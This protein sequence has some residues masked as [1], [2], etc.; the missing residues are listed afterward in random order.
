MKEFDDLKNVWSQDEPATFDFARA[1]NNTNNNPISQMKKHYTLSTLG[2]SATTTFIVWFGFFSG[3]EFMFEISYT[4]LT[5]LSVCLS[6]I[7]LINI[8]TV[9]LISKL[10]ET[11]VPKEYLNNWLNFY[12]KRLRFFRVYAPILVTTMTFSFALYVPEIMGYY[13]NMYYKIGFIFFLF[14]ILFTSYLLGKN[15]ADAEKM[16]LNE[17]NGTFQSL[18]K[19]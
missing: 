7:L 13:P 14:L 11:L 15:A 3:R 8:Y 1:F 5:I 4:A 6:V 19:G 2:L 18:S 9:F 16:K 17:L 12:T 10:D